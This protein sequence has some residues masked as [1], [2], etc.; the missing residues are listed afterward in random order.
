MVSNTFCHLFVVL[1]GLLFS[2]IISQPDNVIG[3]EME[4][5]FLIVAPKAGWELKYLHHSVPK[6]SNKE[7]VF[8]KQFDFFGFMILNQ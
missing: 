6:E 8:E 2:F 4:I 3:R 1:Y 7:I 5:A